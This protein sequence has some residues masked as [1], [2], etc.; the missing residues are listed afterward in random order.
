MPRTSRALQKLR[1]RSLDRAITLR[2]SGR[3]A[4]NIPPNSF[5]GLNNTTQGLAILANDCQIPPPATT[6]PATTTTATTTPATTT[7]ATTAPPT[8][9]A[10][11]AA[12]AAG[13]AG[14]AAAVVGQPRTTG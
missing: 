6:T 7:P 1:T 12:G 13:Q 3:A 10:P 9:A 2:G 4:F 5:N 14:A 11:G 8:G